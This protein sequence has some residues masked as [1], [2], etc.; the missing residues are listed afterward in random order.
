MV[1]GYLSGLQSYL[2][3]PIQQPQINTIE[4]L[5]RSPFTIYTWD[6]TWENRLI[7]VLTNQLDYTN[8]TY[9]VREMDLDLLF[10]ETEIFNRSISFLR[11][12]NYAKVSL[13]AQKRLDIKGY[14]ISRVPVRSS[15]FSYIVNDDFPFIEHL[16]KIIQWTIFFL[17]ELML[18]YKRRTQI[19]HRTKSL[20]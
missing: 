20:S 10:N 1:N 9:K 18:K 7:D 5:Y 17:I 13:K 8:W 15:F 2:T 4:E 16:K 6:E 3:S 11:E 12:M 14:H 19:F